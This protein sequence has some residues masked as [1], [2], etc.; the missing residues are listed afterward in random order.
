MG[1]E[2]YDSEPVFRAA[3][4]RCAEILQPFLD[5]DLRSLL[6]PPEGASDAD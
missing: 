1:R 4:D 3:V 6:Y 2:I 5:A